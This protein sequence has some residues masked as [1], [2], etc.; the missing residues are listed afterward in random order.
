MSLASRRQSAS[1]LG[2]LQRTRAQERTLA[3]LS[4]DSTLT[5]KRDFYFHSQAEAGPAIPQG[6]A[7]APD[8]GKRE[9]TGVMEGHADLEGH[10]ER[11]RGET[12]GTRRPGTE[13]G[14]RLPDGC[15]PGFPRPTGRSGLGLAEKK[16]K[17]DE[18][19][20]T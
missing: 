17:A 18:G 12:V 14:L 15:S 4:S 20:Q 5:R 13:A 6:A 2:G 10:G 7:S 19:P 8:A 11:Q 1:H 3:H 16:P 9:S